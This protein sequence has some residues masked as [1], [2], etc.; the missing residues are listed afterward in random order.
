M[1]HFFY[2]DHKILLN[3]TETQIS[4]SGREFRLSGLHKKG[5][6]PDKWIDGGYRNHWV[7]SYIFLDNQ[8]IIKFEFDYFEKYVGEVK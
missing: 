6:V 4:K 3:T 2:K 7:H 5:Q 8:Q 1:K